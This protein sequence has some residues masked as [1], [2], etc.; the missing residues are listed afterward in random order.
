LGDLLI[1]DV[2]M[3]RVDCCAVVDARGFQFGYC[4]IN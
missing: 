3:E 1:E 2:E 4:R